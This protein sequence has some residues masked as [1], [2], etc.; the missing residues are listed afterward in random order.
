MEREDTDIQEP[1]GQVTSQLASRASP[2][3]FG[4][5]LLEPAGPC[6]KPDGELAAERRHQCPWLPAAAEAK[7]RRANATT[8]ATGVKLMPVV[9]ART[10]R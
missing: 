10:W 3:R 2:E 5:L 8:S 6:P 7:P 4:D 9:I 1:V